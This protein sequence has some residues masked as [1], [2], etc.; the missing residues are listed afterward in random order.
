MKEE[1]YTYQ[2]TDS[3]DSNILSSGPS[4]VLLEWAEDSYTATQHRGSHSGWNL[5][6]D[7]QRN[8]VHQQTYRGMLKAY[9]D[10]EVGRNTSI[11]GV[12]ERR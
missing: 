7:L 6:G 1:V 3:Y 12:L 9:L 5:L 4:A 10:S 2:A 11:V 8:T